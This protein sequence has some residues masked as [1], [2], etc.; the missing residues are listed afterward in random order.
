[1]KK[2]MTFLVAT[3]IIAAP[4]LL[5]PVANAQ[6]Q[7]GYVEHCVNIN[8]LGHWE[9]DIQDQFVKTVLEG[10]RNFYRLYYLQDR[11]MSH[12]DE[13]FH[14]HFSQRGI[15]DEDTTD[16]IASRILAEER[17]HQS[18]SGIIAST[19]PNEKF[20]AWQQEYMV[21]DLARRDTLE[22]LYGVLRGDIDETVW[23]SKLYRIATL[24]GK[25]QGRIEFEAQRMNSDKVAT[26]LKSLASTINTTPASHFSKT[27]IGNIRSGFD[28]QVKLLENKI[29]REKSSQEP[30]KG[31]IEESELLLEDLKE[32]RDDLIGID[33]EAV[34]LFLY[35]GIIPA[36][37]TSIKKLGND[38]VS[39]KNLVDFLDTE[40]SWERY[41][42]DNKD[43]VMTAFY[44]Q[45]DKDAE[46]INKRVITMK[47]SGPGF[48]N[49]PSD[50]LDPLAPSRFELTKIL[51]SM[52]ASAPYTCPD[53]EEPKPT[54]TPV[55]VTVTETTTTPT[56]STVPTTVTTE[57]PTTIVTTTPTTITGEKTTVT[58]DVPTT[59]TT[60][61]LTT[62]TSKEPVPTTVEVTMERV[63][64]SV[65][66]VPTTVGSP[67]T[68][69]EPAPAQVHPP[70][71]I[72]QQEVIAGP[73]VHTGGMVRCSIV[74]SI[75]GLFR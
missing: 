8:P 5:A 42:I 55:T 40:E 36:Y 44:D 60:E 2:I 51:M 62:L 19:T 70:V 71:M 14:A 50:V 57:V 29:R 63:T 11:P 13:F 66:E 49:T 25:P 4:P 1:M 43:A 74:S 33:Q 6:A 69:R 39:I 26:D 64:T 46:L 22:F 41:G 45:L 23:G 65:R 28:Y 17:M 31:V 38:K 12:D 3:S 61:V 15:D 34:E 37:N 32:S 58:T 20:D 56:T 7:S 54:P 27:F 35:E 18:F 67:T 10:N 68:V 72:Q 73:T 16:P 59:V 47:N 21:E 9:L 53:P 30:K 24:T 48:E 75:I 52:Y